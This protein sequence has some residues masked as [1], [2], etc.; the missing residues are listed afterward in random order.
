MHWETTTLFLEKLHD[1]DD[2]AWRLLSE[3][4]RGPLI[5]FGVRMG[6][7]ESAAEDAAQDT[8]LRFVEAYRAGRY[9][10]DRGR[11]GAWLFTLAFNSIRSMLRD[12]GRHR[13][14][15]LGGSGA[16]ES[17]PSRED[18]RAMWEDD[19]ERH[20]LNTC[21]VQLRHEADPIHFRAFEL[22]ALM[23]VPPEEIASQL[24]VTRDSVYRSRYRLLKRLRELKADY[25]LLGA[26][27]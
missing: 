22:H 25:E 16:L 5:R 4:Y 26:I 14:A 7:S 10:R 11:L 3:R 21:M 24:G 6:L 8:M 13:M 23:G 18:A 2:Q 27:G 20:V 17:V 19:W 12:A 1:A 9:D 15:L